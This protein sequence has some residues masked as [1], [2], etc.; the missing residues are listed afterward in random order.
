MGAATKST[1][2]LADSRRS[3]LKTIAA[4]R[5]T[6]VTSL[7]SEGADL[8]IE[9]YRGLADADEL[10]QRAAAARARLRRGLY[11]GSGTPQRAD[12][13]LYPRRSRKR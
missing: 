13:V 6:T 8:V 11:A 9:K 7:L 5:G 10:S 1:F 4:Q 3:A 12:D 2:L